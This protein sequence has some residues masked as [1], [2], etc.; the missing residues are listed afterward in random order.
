MDNENII[1]KCF[2]FADSEWIVE[3]IILYNFNCI[4]R[5]IETDEERRFSL[6]FV[7]KKIKT[8]EKD[9]GKLIKKENAFCFEED[10]EKELLRK[11][12]K[13]YPKERIVEL[14]SNELIA[15]TNILKELNINT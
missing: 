1:N 10:N 4:C 2:V 3:E 14:S 8:Y 7:D 15:Y 5:N 6:E 12:V 13:Y 9:L 11:I